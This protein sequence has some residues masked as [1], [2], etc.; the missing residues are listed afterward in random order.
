LKFVITD[1]DGKKQSRL[2]NFFGVNNKN[3]PNFRLIDFKKD[4]PRIFSLNKF[5]TSMQV[6]S[7]VNNWKTGKTKIYYPR[8]YKPRSLFHLF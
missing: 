5:D 7:F 6:I 1:I 3:L 8:L 4:R 2:A